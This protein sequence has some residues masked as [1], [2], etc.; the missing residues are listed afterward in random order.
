MAAG[1]SSAIQAIQQVSTR[2]GGS[3]AA[4]V[5]R[6]MRTRSCLTTNRSSNESGTSN[7]PGMSMAGLSAMDSEGGATNG[8]MVSLNQGNEQC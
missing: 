6:H 8:L 4:A 2:P 3:P 7:N 1:R 5:V